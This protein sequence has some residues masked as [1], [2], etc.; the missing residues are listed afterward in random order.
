MFQ[1]HAICFFMASFLATFVPT[2]NAA[3]FD[4]GDLAG[5]D[6]MYLDI[7]EDTSTDGMLFGTPDITGNTLDFD[8][9]SFKADSDGPTFVDS[10]LNFTLMSNSNDIEL[11]DVFIRERGDFTLTGLGDAQAL[12]T[13]GTNV[14]FTITQLNGADPP[15]LLPTGSGIMIFTPDATPD[16][17][18][19]FN[20]DNF[21]NVT[22]ETW[23]GAARP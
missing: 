19:Q 11:T 18:G 14:S 1:R 16:D 9:T 23:T 13:V 21:G 4:Y 5:P 17:P 15:D 8:P 12:A 2:A 3:F 6:V 20:L 22:T 10:Q 7:T